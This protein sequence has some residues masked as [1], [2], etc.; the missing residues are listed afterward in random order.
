ML[1]YR[2]IGFNELIMLF[3][4]KNPIYGRKLWASS[5]WTLV[6]NPP[7]YGVVCFFTD[8]L[9]CE[10]GTENLRYDRCHFIN[11]RWYITLDSDCFD[12]ESRL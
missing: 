3:I 5:Q 2:S 11:A 12:R 9:E 1:G 8:D 4:A 6:N 10:I 7:D